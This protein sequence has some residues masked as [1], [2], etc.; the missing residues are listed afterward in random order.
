MAE[1]VPCGPDL[2][3]HVEMIRKYADAGFDE[4]YIQQIGPRQ[5]EFFAAYAEHVLRQ[6]GR[7]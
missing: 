6:F 4:L 5:D 1:S 2:D 3:Q 7:A